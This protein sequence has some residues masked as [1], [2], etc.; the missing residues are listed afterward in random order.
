MAKPKPLPSSL[1]E[2]KRY[3]VYEVVAEKEV[4]IDV[5]ADEIYRH[6]MEILGELGM[7]EISLWVMKN[8]F[9]GRKGLIRVT[10]AGVERIRL[11]LSSIRQI[12]EIPAIIDVLGVTG[13]IRAARLKYLKQE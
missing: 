11:V 2:K 12:D 5:L 13:T 4:D 7:S 9:S 10:P 6:A 1:R 3:V 8:L